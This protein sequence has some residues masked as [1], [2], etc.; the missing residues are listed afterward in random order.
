MFV[1]FN[2]HV[3]CTVCSKGTCFKGTFWSSISQ[4]KNMENGKLPVM[5]STPEHATDNWFRLHQLFILMSS[6]D[7]ELERR[8]LLLL[9]RLTLIPEFGYCLVF[10]LYQKITHQRWRIL[11]T[12]AHENGVNLW[13]ATSVC[14]FFQLLG[15]FLR[16]SKSSQLFFFFF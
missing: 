6:S 3:H 16:D 14:S 1:S 2:L 15:I 13:F 7:S 10:S 4:M 9:L 8:R 12:A 5:K 11:C